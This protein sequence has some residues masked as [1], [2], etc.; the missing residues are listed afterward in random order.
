[1]LG[2]VRHRAGSS[3]FLGKAKETKGKGRGE[4]GS[5]ATGDGAKGPQ[6]SERARE[7]PGTRVPAEGGEGGEWVSKRRW[8]SEGPPFS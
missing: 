7:W 1:M 8:A 2:Q 3:R 5:A 4:K 6:R